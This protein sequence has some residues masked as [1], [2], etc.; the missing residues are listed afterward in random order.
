MK[1]CP[2]CETRYD[3]EILRF[4]TKDG[5]PLIDENQPSFTEM[6]SA[7]SAAED[8]LNE[9]TLVSYKPSKDLT[10]RVSQP[11]TERTDAPRIVIPMNEQKKEQQVR[12]RAIPPYQ[13]LSPK[14]NTGKTVALTILGTLAILALGLGLFYFVR[15]DDSSNN[16]NTLNVNTNPPDANLNT[17][18]N[19]GGFN[20]NV[21]TTNLNVNTNF[22]LGI[23]NLN[24]NI[25]TPTPTATST[26]TP[27]P[28]PTA[29]AS[30]NSNTGNL[31]TNSAPPS[32]KPSLTPKPSITATPT[33]KV[34][35]SPTTPPSGR[36]PVN[37]G[38]LNGRAVS[39]PKPAYPQAARQARA[40]GQVS[41]QV[42][43]DEEGNVMSAKATT[44]NPLLRQSAEAA[45]RQ[46]R[47]NPVTMN[48]QP[49][50]AIGILLY[51]FVN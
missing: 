51:N 22:N 1:F 43:V 26:P 11:E 7:G 23:S 10:D 3:E 31:N 15:T 20:Y 8:D 35:P 45:A 38:V 27:K 2:T 5:T 6:P 46:T 18:L 34:S 33:P 36:P 39:L 30:I 49:V 14:S 29:T 17:N 19:L 12:S 13:P 48:N 9:D 25:K 41:V 16:K 28:S 40:N 21:P 44:G 32:P 50:K 42:L 4:C 24:T 37:A 47:F